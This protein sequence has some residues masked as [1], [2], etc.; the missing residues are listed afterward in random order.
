MI[1]LLFYLIF[2]FTFRLEDKI[3]TKQI[4]IN[5][6]TFVTMTIFFSEVLSFFQAFRIINI[7]YSIAFLFIFYIFYL[8]K[9]IKNLIFIYVKK[10]I[11]NYFFQGVLFFLILLIF[12]ALRYFPSSFD[13]NCYHLPRLVFWLQ[14]GTLE[15]FATPIYRMVYQPYCTEVIFCF[16]YSSFGPMSTIHIWNILMFLQ[17][18]VSLRFLSNNLS[19]LFYLNNL[20][21]SAVIFICWSILVASFDS[22]ND[23]QLTV[24]LVSYCGLLLY[25]IKFEDEKSLFPIFSSVT[26]GFLTK[27]TFIFYFF[28]TSIF[29][30]FVYLQKRRI[31][32]DNYFLLVKCCLRNVHLL[33]FCSVLLIPSI[34]RN[35]YTSESL[36]GPNKIES[37]SYRNSK[38]GI[39]EAISNTSKNLYCQ[40]LTPL[41]SL[42]KITYDI[43]VA[44]HKKMNLPSL[45]ENGLNWKGTV[46]TSVSKLKNYFKPETLPN[47]LLFCTSVVCLIISVVSIVINSQN[48]SSAIIYLKMTGWT[49]LFLF[50]FSMVFRWQAWHTR[51]LFP[52]FVYQAYIAISFLNCVKLSNYLVPFVIFSGL[53]VILFNASQPIFKSSK[54]T[55][56]VFINIDKN[57]IIKS[58]WNDEFQYVRVN[59]IVGRTKR[60]GLF[61]SWEDERIF[62]YVYNFRD[63]SNKYFLMGIF[64]NPSDKHFQGVDIKTLDYIIT[65]S[66]DDFYL[67]KT[68]C[69]DLFRLEYKTPFFLNNQYWYLYKNAGL[70]INCEL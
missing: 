32:I 22:K 26:I 48:K 45:N 23:L 61:Y 31:K 35:L 51:I 41:N 28:C 34:R 14:N 38:I 12:P 20:N 50:L 7:Q 46:V 5:N 37:E 55:T 67:R 25:F 33:I 68:Y 60:I 36:L 39:R 2:T 18:F 13:A 65:N 69:M 66:R 27:G 16:I 15:H 11:N 59:K 40:T 30:Y 3:D 44:I 24:F 63:S 62:P 10:I 49:F 8:F 43:L 54:L 56:S 57:L 19:K 52:L 4:V 42:N 53:F 1:Y 17:L 29:F 64:R 58:S 21:L 9:N 47:V 6:I 70:P